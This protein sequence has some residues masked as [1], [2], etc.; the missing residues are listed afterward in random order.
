MG[1]ERMRRGEETAQEHA[2]GPR[3]H[4]KYGAVRA[5]QNGAWSARDVN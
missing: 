5:T 1:E 3:G 2:T 4:H